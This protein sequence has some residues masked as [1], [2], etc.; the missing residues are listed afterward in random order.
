[1]LEYV[2][3]HMEK[4]ENASNFKSQKKKKPDPSW[5]KD[6]KCELQKF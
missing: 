5:I 4:K 6:L 2:V 1:M 3:I